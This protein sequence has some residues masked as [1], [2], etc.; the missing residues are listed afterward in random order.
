MSHIEFFKKEAKNL[1]KDW[2]TQT[3]TTESDRT[4]SYHYDSKFYNVEDLFKSLN[5]DDK[6]RQDMKLARVQHLIAKI[7][8]FKNWNDLIAASKSELEKAEKLL[9]DLKEKSKLAK[10]ITKSDAK[11][12]TPCF[13]IRCMSEMTLSE[14]K[15]F[16]KEVVKIINT[17]EESVKDSEYWLDHFDFWNPFDDSRPEKTFYE[18]R[19]Y[20]KKKLKNRKESYSKIIIRVYK[21]FFTRPYLGCCSPVVITGL[22]G[23]LGIR[24]FKVNLKNN[25]ISGFC[26]RFL[27]P[28]FNSRIQEPVI[29]INE[30]YCNTPERF[31]KEIAT[32]LY[33]M[34]AKDDEFD[35][36]EMNGIRFEMASTQ[37][38][39]EQFAE[40]LFISLNY[41][42]EFLKSEKPYFQSF[43]PALTKKEKEFFL[44]NY[45]FEHIVNRIKSVFYIDYRTAIK[46]LLESDW[47][48]KFMFESF[49]AAEQFYLECLKRHDEKYA[50]P[51]KYLNGE[52][53]PLSWTVIDMDA[54]KQYIY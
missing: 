41:L 13:R 11:Q 22:V 20:L 40:D 23:Q 16:K 6:D 15:S 54:S 39:A 26:T 3:T 4:I 25:K 21:Y 18:R 33:Y 24:V 8:G 49:E 17:I 37:H 31:L 45:E 38:E 30:N 43:S 32:Q 53:E 9:R 44:Q 14:E 51:I 48:Y 35:F 10:S 52:P 29:V 7:T 5:L 19:D 36:V 34:I 50:E 27:N 46:K 12:F 2:K 1:F 28:D 42:N 47:E